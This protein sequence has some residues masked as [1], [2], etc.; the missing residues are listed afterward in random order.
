[1]E[2]IENPEEGFSHWYDEEFHGSAIEPEDYCQALVEEM[3]VEPGD[4][5][6]SGGE[7][8]QVRSITTTSDS[9]AVED[10]TCSSPQ[11]SRGGRWD[12]SIQELYRDW[13]R[14]KAVPAAL[15]VITDEQ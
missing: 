3:G 2:P 11:D 1:M 6:E 15:T 5:F 7:A 8:Y 9:L 4:V 14:G 12:I 13:K 10:P